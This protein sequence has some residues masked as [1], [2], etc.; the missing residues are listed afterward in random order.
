[1]FFEFARNNV[2]R[3]TGEPSHASDLHEQF[4]SALRNTAM[5][6]GQAF[7]RRF[8]RSQIWLICS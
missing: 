7:D 2:F 8:R 4:E 1:M 6:W 3:T 5:T